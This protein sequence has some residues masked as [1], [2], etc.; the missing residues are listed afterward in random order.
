MEA[1]KRKITDILS[2]STILQIPHFQRSY[3]W[4]Q[5]QWSRFIDDME[6]A[7]RQNNPYFM[8]SVILKQQETSTE[9]LTRDVRTVID[10]QQR[11]TTFLLF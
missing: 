7:S 10:G 8:G 4:D 6:Y 1:G 5:D 11:L 3:V 9:Y 2:R